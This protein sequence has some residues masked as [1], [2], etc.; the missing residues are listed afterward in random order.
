MAVFL[1]HTPKWMRKVYPGCIWQVDTDNKDIYLTFDDGPIPEVTPWVVD[2]LE[3]YHIKAT[4]FLVGDNI[5]KHPEV[6]RLLVDNGHLVANHTYYHKNG[7]Q[8]TDQ[9]YYEEINLCKQEMLKNGY[10][11]NLL[12]RP[13]HGRI[14]PKQIKEISA[15]GYD[16]VLWSLLSGDFSPSLTADVIL[17]KLKKHLQPGTIAVFHDSLKAES[18]MKATLEPFIEYCIEKDYQFKLIKSVR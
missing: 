13:P 3:K 18:L 6:F 11:D 9:E 10:D 2:L 15:M 7:F 4:F 8:L 5:K 12:F 1:H 17:K 16:L 14:K